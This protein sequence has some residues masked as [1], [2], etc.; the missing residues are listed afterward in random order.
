MA[1]PPTISAT[2]SGA[3]T[4]G[5]STPTHT[6]LHTEAKTA[7]ADI[8]AEL[9]AGPKGASADL[10][11]RLSALDTTVAAKQ[12]SDATLTALA[13]LD[14]TAGLV[15]ETAADNFTK[16]TLVADAGGSLV[17]NNGTGAGGNPTISRAA[18]T[19]DVTAGADSNATTIA[20]NAVTT[21]KIADSNVTL[22]KLANIAASTVLGNNTG[23]A[24][25]PIALTLD[26]LRTLLDM[27]GA[28]RDPSNAVVFFDD[29]TADT[30]FL[31]TGWGLNNS[32]GGASFITTFQDAA[33]PGNFYL[34]T[35]TSA[36]G[37]TNHRQAGSLFRTFGGGAFTWRMLCRLPNLSTVGEEFIVDVG[38]GDDT[39]AASG[40]AGNGIYFR[41]D[42]LGLGVNW[43]LVT[44]KAGTRTRVDT[45]VAVITGAWIELA[46]TVD[47][48]AT[49]VQA[50]INDS[51][52]GSPSVT[53]IPNTTSNFCTRRNRMTKSAGTTERQFHYDYVWDKLVLTNPR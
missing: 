9:G 46:F 44:A 4:L 6:A 12:A 37:A 28:E 29:M 51:N 1:Y 11:A 19:G 35:L 36:T 21:A 32:G 53:N 10:T 7:V 23:G 45:G 16:R 33:H 30:N 49:S 20:N 42:R 34:T 52:A 38:Y 50:V 18:L 48:G 8:V 5:G 3:S 14:A 26:Q 41:Y 40:E 39:S 24:A 47:A 17:V 43:F 27:T 22:A 31:S 13:G 2:P 25:A 15:V